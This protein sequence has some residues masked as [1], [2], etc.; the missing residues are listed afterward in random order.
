MSAPHPKQKS[1]WA[2]RPRPLPPT[3]MAT[4]ERR[5]LPRR[6]V[7]ANPAMREK[8]EASKRR[9]VRSGAFLLESQHPPGRRPLRQSILRS[10][11]ALED[12]GYAEQGPV[13]AE[14]R[15][16]AVSRV[17][18]DQPQHVQISNR[19]RHSTAP[20]EAKRLRLVSATQPRSVFG[21][22]GRMRLTA[23]S[24][25]SFSS[26]TAT[27]RPSH[28]DFEGIFRRSARQ[29]DGGGGLFQGKAMGDQLPHVELAGENQPRHFV[30][31][32]KIG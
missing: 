1:I 4:A 17:V 31:Q 26:G 19:F 16:A 20:G 32:R 15:S 30:L 12:R 24:P 9:L 21:G 28:D 7:S 5:F 3:L 11:A 22:S 10:E 13:V 2:T 6:L 18:R 25:V 8:T 14:P 27:R 29:L 23:E